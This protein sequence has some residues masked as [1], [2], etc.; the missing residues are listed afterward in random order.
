[1]LFGTVSDTLATSVIYKQV[2][3]GL[4]YRARYRVRNVIGWSSYSP[5]GYLRAASR[6]KAPSAPIYIAATSTTITVQLGRSLDDGGAVVQTYELWI[7]AGDLASDFS[8]VASYTGLET[9]FV[10]DQAIET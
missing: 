3:R 1:V 9:S 5:I 8:Q 7:D 10:I 6:P 2:T 4:L